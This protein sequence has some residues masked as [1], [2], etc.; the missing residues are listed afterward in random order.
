MKL[1][2]VIFITGIIICGF[3][4]FITIPKVY[5]KNRLKV[6]VDEQVDKKFFDSESILVKYKNK[7]G[8]KVLKV[9]ESDKSVQPALEKVQKDAVKKKLL[10][11]WEDS[12]V[13]FVQPNYLYRS[14]DWVNQSGY[15]V[16]ISFDELNH[17]YY[18]ESGLVNTWELQG[19]PESENCGGSKEVI[20]A[21]IDSGLAF[22]NYN[23]TEGVTRAQYI[24]SPAFSRINLFTNTEEIKGNSLDDDCNGYVDDFNGVDTFS[25]VLMD[26][27]TCKDGIPVEVPIEYVKSGHPVDT[28]GHGTYVTG[29]IA[30]DISNGEIGTVS[31]AFNISIMPISANIYFDGFF[32]TQSIIGGINYAID[33]NADIINMSLAAYQ[34][35]QL[36]EESIE[37]AFNE[38]ILMIAAAGN[39][40]NNG[41][42]YPAA[43]EQVF[44]VGAVNIDHTRSSYSNYGDDL[45]IVA[46][47]GD[48]PLLE[49]NSVYQSTLACFIDYCNNNNIGSGFSSFNLIGTSFAAPQVTSLAAL[50]KSK[51]PEFSSQQI[52][53]KIIQSSIDIGEIGKDEQTGYGVINYE[54]AM[55]DEVNESDEGDNSDEVNETGGGNSSGGVN[56]SNG[57]KEPDRVDEQNKQDELSEVYRF[58]SSKLQSHFY[59]VDL[60]EKNYVEENF[61]DVW[62]YEK[63][64]FYA[65]ENEGDEKVGPVYRFWSSKLQAHFYTSSEYEKNY[66]EENF[67]DVW[68]YE[69]VAFYAIENEGDEKVG[70]VYRFWSSKLQA[71]FYTS[72]EYEKN[73]VEE[74]FSDVWSYE[75]VAFYA[76]ENEGDEKVGPAHIFL[77]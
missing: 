70:P 57:L 56:E 51:N 65:T 52:I 72:S 19:C 48:D 61:S 49:K 25:A 66:V 15:N 26:V 21:V 24:A 2:S 58:Y 68:S 46:Y 9:G 29:L 74:N 39:E 27:E 40:A 71:H 67:S 76:T 63:V 60:V 13:E 54:K 55:T 47:V 36:L 30:S 10:K 62:S 6:I 16:P 3:L 22:E 50:I 5:S 44:S 64:A 17:W 35:D 42:A 73:Y 1:N 41:L 37:E 7:K 53:D 32:T 20:V 8:F 11:I 45:D 77:K 14:S 69:K 59:T 75:K 38:D 34:E 31:P 33:N 12:S 23:D 28:Y 18:L 4:L 43:Y